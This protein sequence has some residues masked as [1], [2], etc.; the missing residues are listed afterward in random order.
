MEAVRQG[1]AARVARLLD[2][3]PALLRASANGVSAILMA[4]YCG[5]PSIA[6]LFVDR[7]AVLSFH[8]ACAVGDEA[9]AARLLEADPSLLDR[10][11]EDGFPP[12]GLAIFFRH[13]ALA[14]RLIEAG[15]DVT[16]VAANAQRV[17]P[18]HA[19]A[20]V[21][22]HETMKLLLDRGADPN[23]RQ[24]LDY[25]PL[26][27]AASRGDL[28]LGKLLIERGADAHARSTDGKTA[29]DIARDRGQEGFARWME[30]HVAG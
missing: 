7:G 11:G 15:A 2:D 3:D 1:D 4:M 8:E 29:I 30:Q 5:H 20:A 6:Q 27:A 24:Q 21:S 18:V 22:D 19:A 16:T 26:F 23:A 10:P 28:I 14:R 12:L 13:P 25:T 9:A 17:A